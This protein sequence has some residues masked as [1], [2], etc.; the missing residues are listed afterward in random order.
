MTTEA[1]SD[2]PEA[3]PPNASREDVIPAER[4]LAGRTELL[5]ELRGEYYRLRMTR[6]GRLIL[7]K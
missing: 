6:R 5:I 4:L 2:R 1:D 7:T 3:Q